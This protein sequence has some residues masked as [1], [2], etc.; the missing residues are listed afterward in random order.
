MKRK[1]R[2]KFWKK[3]LAGFDFWRDP[4]DAKFYPD[5]A[6]WACD[7]FP[8]NLCFTT[9]EFAGKPFILEE[10]QQQIIGHLFGW[11][12]PDGS[13]RFRYLFLYIPRK[14]G[15]TELAAGLGVLFFVADG[16]PAAEVYCGAKTKG[17]ANIF[18]SKAKRMVK[19]NP[20]L[21]D[22]VKPPKGRYSWTLY[23]EETE[24][25][26]QILASDEASAQGFNAHAGVID[27]LHTLAD[28]GF[29]GALRESMGARRQP[30]LAEL[31][32][33]ADVDN[34]YCNEQL[35]YAEQVR[36]GVISDSTCMPIVFRALD[37]DD[38]SDPATWY[39]CNPNLGVSIKE[40]FIRDQYN[41]LSRTT[42]G[43]IR[44]K[45][46]F[47]NMQTAN[48]KSWLDVDF[49]DHCRVQQS[50][51]DLAGAH[52][53]GAIDRSAVND[54]SALALYFPD[55]ASFLFDFIVPRETAESNAAYEQWA[56]AGYIRI[57]EFSAIRDDELFE[58]VADAKAKY[59]IRGIGYDP[60]R[61]SS[62]ADWLSKPFGVADSE[63]NL[64]EFGL[65]I[66]VAA[67]KQDFRTLS[68]PVND[69]EIA[70]R[71]RT[72][73][74]FGNPVMRWMMQN[75][76]VTKDHKENI[77]IVKENPN[78]PKKI[79]GVVTMIMAHK[80]ATDVSLFTKDKDYS[81]MEI[82]LL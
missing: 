29:P 21:N 19:F 59:D 68:G 37:K 1:R 41:K 8:E 63:E 57:S 65:G 75:S 9:G 69:V 27:E 55:Y 42:S 17:Q 20:V 43:I 25:T 50:S 76:R 54:I 23:D 66:P 67:I 16:E 7:F 31:T 61:M 74:H 36:D 40:S 72:V 70:I 34:E 53:F 49:W 28:G 38:V 77:K 58:M 4:G 39:K 45:K 6:E 30:L 56:K 14:N 32:T 10:W 22:R 79:D 11:L 71:N 52:C 26:M 24:S 48:N 15:K 35:A 82:R 3:T 73:R 81:N 18:F 64:R 2:Y 12:R 62:L 33:A 60:W 78:S 13:R 80:T 46:Y 44:F 51:I 5:L 47:L